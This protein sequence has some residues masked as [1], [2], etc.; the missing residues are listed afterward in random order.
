[1]VPEFT[2]SDSRSRKISEEEYPRKN[3]VELERKNSCEPPKPK[4]KYP[5]ASQ[6]E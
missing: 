5:A 3:S 1:M 6:Q 4:P 2:I